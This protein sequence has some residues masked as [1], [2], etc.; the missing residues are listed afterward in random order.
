[1]NNHQIFTTTKIDKT[2]R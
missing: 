1:M 2:F